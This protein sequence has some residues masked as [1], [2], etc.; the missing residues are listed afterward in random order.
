M[1]QSI[2]NIFKYSRKTDYSSLVKQGAIIVD[3]RSKDEFSEGHIINA[4]NIPV[5]EIKNH[6]RVLDQNRPIICCCVSGVRSGA[7][8]TILESNGYRLVHNGGNW[9]ELLHKL[10]GITT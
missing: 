4:M 2:K 10:S 7:A 6:L 5:R 3:V 8:K 1:L 9:L